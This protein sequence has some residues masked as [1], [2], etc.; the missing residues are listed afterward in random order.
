MPSG[1]SVGAGGIS[2]SGGIG[3]LAGNAGGTVATGGSSL[4]TA[5]ACYP[6]SPTDNGS[7]NTLMGN[8]ISG[9]C[10]SNCSAISPSTAEC[11]PSGC[12]VTLAYCQHAPRGIAADATSVYWTG[13][14]MGAVMKMP[15]GGGTPATL[16]SGLNQPLGIALDDSS[17]YWTDRHAGTVMKVPVGGGTPVTLASGQSYPRPSRWMPPAFATRPTVQ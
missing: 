16:A 2:S 9:G 14:T 5:D 3:G 4:T 10:A 8:D 1:G 6:G 13:S 17:V 7:L 11:T 12:L 15:P